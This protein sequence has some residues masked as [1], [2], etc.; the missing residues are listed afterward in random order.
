[1][2]RMRSEQD[3]NFTSMDHDDV[4][5]FYMG[6]RG[7]QHDRLHVHTT[8][9]HSTLPTLIIINKVLIDCVASFFGIE[10]HTFLPEK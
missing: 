6:M 4:P 10:Q 2:L 5:F 7:L 9:A 1:M 8:H 3:H